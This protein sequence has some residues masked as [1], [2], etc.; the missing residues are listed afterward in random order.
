MGPGRPGAAGR[1]GCDGSGR[2][3]PERR[4]GRRAWSGR[5]GRRAGRAGG[6]LRGAAPRAVSE[7][8]AP[9]R[10]DG[11]WAARVAPGRYSDLRCVDGASAARCDPSAMADPAGPEGV[12]AAAAAGVAGTAGSADGGPGRRGPPAWALPSAQAG[13]P[14]QPVPEPAAA[15]GAPRLAS[16][17]A[18]PRRRLPLK[19]AA[20]RPAGRARASPS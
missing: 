19:A 15:P 1:I 6:R 20:R 5:T 3:P 13:V 8:R 9:S 18:R 16:V 17:A 10:P 12:A 7:L 4:L 2:G 14:P 11:R